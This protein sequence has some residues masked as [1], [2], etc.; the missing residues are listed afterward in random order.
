MSAS[1]VAD[2][3]RFSRCSRVHR[4]ARVARNGSSTAVPA[5]IVHNTTET[6]THTDEKK[7]TDTKTDAKTD[8]KTE[9]ETS[10]AAQKTQTTSASLAKTRSLRVLNDIHNLADQGNVSA[11]A[12][13]T[14]P[15][16]RLCLRGDMLVMSLGQWTL[17]PILI[18][19][20]WVLRAPRSN[21][22]LA[23]TKWIIKPT[24]NTKKNTNIVFSASLGTDLF[25]SR[26]AAVR[27]ALRLQTPANS[28][29]QAPL[30]AAPM[31]P[32][33]ET[34]MEMSVVEASMEASKKASKKAS[35][36]SVRKSKSKE[37]MTTTRRRIRKLTRGK[38][39]CAA[40]V[41]NPFDDPTADA[42]DAVTAI[43]LLTSTAAT[44]ERPVLS[45]A[46]P[47]Q[48]SL[49]AHLCD[50]T[51]QVLPRTGRSKSKSK[52]SKESKGSKCTN[53]GTGQTT[54]KRRR[55]KSES[56][57][58]A[59]E[60]AETSVT[61]KTAETSVTTK[62]LEAFLDEPIRP[63]VYMWL[64]WLETTPL[65]FSCLRVSSQMP[66]PIPPPLLPQMPPQMPESVVLGTKADSKREIDCNLAELDASDWPSSVSLP[67][68]AS[69]DS[70]EWL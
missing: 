25:E 19:D 65:P 2:V 38:S 68:V 24:I 29:L 43:S 26:D 13:L 14:S 47:S 56:P 4:I 48:M 1:V 69:F 63:D 45:I 18:D 30:V 17:M 52:G 3:P 27:E 28:E 5:G 53:K 7:E 50:P 36:L 40:I 57:T 51:F 20:L 49:P 54:G 31:E 6:D 44:V 32:S 21:I 12:W 59:T 61:T 37:K 39:L 10:T 41:K 66:L 34:P 22:H 42:A 67:S 46:A 33:L 55:S 70:F 15:F 23:R 62:E 11:R 9:T 58:K 8:A 64:Q 60:T 35:T 16:G